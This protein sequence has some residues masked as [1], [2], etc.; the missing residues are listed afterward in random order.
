MIDCQ[1]LVSLRTPDPQSMTAAA[2]L[3]ARAGFHADL[4]GLDRNVYYEVDVRTDDRERGEAAITR[5]VAE[6][7]LFAN[8]NKERCATVFEPESAAV[9]AGALLVWDREGAE[10]RSLLRRIERTVPGTPV[11]AVR[12]GTLWIPRYSRPPSEWVELS[13]R[14]AEGDGRL[15]S[16]LANPNCDAFAVIETSLAQGTLRRAVVA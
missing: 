11:V 10:D 3:R 9:P 2:T 16:L 6:T 7:T 15:S 5:L 4:A 1:L 8:P 14:L 12:R 13:R